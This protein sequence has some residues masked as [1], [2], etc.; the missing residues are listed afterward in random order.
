[1]PKEIP[2]QPQSD[3]PCGWPAKTQRERRRGR[4]SGASK[5]NENLFENYNKEILINFLDNF[6]AIL[7]VATK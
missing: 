5:L 3:I 7:S 1:M 4:P 2:G 6:L